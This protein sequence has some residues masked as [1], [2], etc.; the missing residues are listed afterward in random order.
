MGT[1]YLL[2]LRGDMNTSVYNSH[3][4]IWYNKYST[5]GQYELFSVIKYNK[6][7]NKN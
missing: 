4:V 5:I 1:S 3:M 2:G 6:N 7:K